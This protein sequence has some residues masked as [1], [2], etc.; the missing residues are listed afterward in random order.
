[1][2]KNIYSC[3]DKICLRDPHGVYID[4]GNLVLPL[5]PL[6][7]LDVD[8]VINETFPKGGCIAGLEATW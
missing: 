3:D 6:T 2:S 1:M 8:F 5:D 4:L 7:I